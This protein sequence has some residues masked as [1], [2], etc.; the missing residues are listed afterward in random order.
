MYFRRLSIRLIF[1]RFKKV[2]S[3][4]MRKLLLEKTLFVLFS[5]FLLLIKILGLLN[6]VIAKWRIC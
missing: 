2:F 4:K 6:F 5:L 3:C 1:L